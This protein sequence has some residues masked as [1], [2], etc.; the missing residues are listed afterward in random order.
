MQ[1]TPRLALMLTLPPLLWAGNAVAGRMLV[2]LVPPLLL[3]GLRWSGALLLLLLLGR[4]ALATA[5]RRAAI[6][7]RWGYFSV[8]G[9]LGVGAYNALQYLAL[10]TSTPINVTLIAS[11]MPLWMLTVGALFFRERP[12][13]RQLLGAA[14]SLAGV[15][16]VMGRGDPAALAQVHFVQGDLFML[17]AAASWAGYSWLLVRPPASMQG[18]ARPAIV[19]SDGSR[20][21]WN[22]SE[23]LL[24]QALF[25]IVW[26]LGAAGAEAVVAPRAPQWTPLVALLLLYIV[27]G[28]SLLAYWFWGRAVAQAGPTTAGIFS[29]L[30][31]LFAA[32]MSTLLIGE[33]PQAYHAAAFALIV[34]GIAVTTLR[35]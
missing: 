34:A 16:T 19:A 7:A 32:L 23:F 12:Q 14:L 1:L 24:V 20:R 15:A 22:W 29:N 11:S 13:P 21:P 4:A 2:P 33:A 9:L 10:T 26:A 17:A 6:R 28:P 25:G 3:N 8:L 27:L 30:T 18:E 5:E 31:P 35:R